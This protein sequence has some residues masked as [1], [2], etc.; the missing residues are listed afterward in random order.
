MS[1]AVS[2]AFVFA[3]L[4]A[5]APGGASACSV[6]IGGEEESR[7]AFIWTTVLLS[8][9]PPGMVGGL[10]WWLWRRSRESEQRLEASR[11]VSGS[12]AEPSIPQ[13]IAIRPSL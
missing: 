12:G 11:G 2:L 5:L 3:A 4:C 6:C 9:L 8:V 7:S 13:G 10:V 1:R